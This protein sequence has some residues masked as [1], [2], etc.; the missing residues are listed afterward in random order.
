MSPDEITRILAAKRPVPPAGLRARVLAAAAS[1]ERRP[2]WWTRIGTW[3]AAAAMLVLLEAWLLSSS[4]PDPSPASA[5]ADVD[6]AILPAPALAWLVRTAPST[7]WAPTPRSR[8]AE[9]LP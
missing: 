3:A 9:I 7:G 4:A 1:V 6:P 8:L 2:P 5:Q